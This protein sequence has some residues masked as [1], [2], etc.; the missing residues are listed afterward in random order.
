M[1][2]QYVIRL[3]FNI[4][5]SNDTSNISICQYINIQLDNGHCHLDMSIQL[6]PLSNWIIDIGNWIPQYHPCTAHGHVLG[7]NP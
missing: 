3:V 6:S 2:I 7:T 4:Y 1:L 5:V